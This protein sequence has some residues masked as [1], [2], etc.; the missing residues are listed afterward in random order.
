LIKESLPI[1]IEL[2]SKDIEFLKTEIS[3]IKQLIKD[4]ADEE[5][6]TWERLLSTKSA[7]WV[8]NLAKIVLGII[9]S[10]FVGGLLYLV[11][12]VAPIN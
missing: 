3:E 4:H 10:S 5:R 2:M 1:K 7:I 12:H 6:D 11:W 9:I 8:E